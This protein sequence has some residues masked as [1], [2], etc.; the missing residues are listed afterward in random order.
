MKKSLTVL[1]AFLLIANYSCKEKVDF[2]KEKEAIMAVLEEIDA[3]YDASDFERWSAVK[4]Q[5]STYISVSASKFG[6]NYNFRWESILENV[7]PNLVLKREPQKTLYK[8]LAN[9]L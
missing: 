9:K 3:A 7:K 6:Y 8:N 1:I 5:D 2:E 4:V